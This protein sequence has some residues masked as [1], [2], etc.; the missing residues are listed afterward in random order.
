MTRSATL[1]APVSATTTLAEIAEDLV[2]AALADHPDET[3]LSLLAISVSHLRHDAALQLEL[4]LH[5]DDEKRRPGTEKGA[6]RWIADRAMDAIRD[7]FGRQSIGYGSV[8]LQERGS[9]PDAF[10]ALAERDL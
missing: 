8:V 10:R 9:V 1:P 7:R 3:A 6:R 2:R 4:P 5:L